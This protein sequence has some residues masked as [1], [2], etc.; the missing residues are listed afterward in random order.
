MTLPRELRAVFLDVGGPVY[1]DENFVAAV[2]TALDEMRSAAGQ[3]PVMQMGVPCS[4]PLSLLSSVVSGAS[5]VLDE[6]LQ[7]R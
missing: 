4:P 5:K 7:R 1:D 6:L 2:L 3:L